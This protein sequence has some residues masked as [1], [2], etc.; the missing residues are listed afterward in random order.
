MATG[1]LVF[2]SCSTVST[3]ID[4]NRAAF[5]QLAP[6]DRE[7][8]RQ[9]KIRGGMSEEA[10]FIAWGRPEQ[11][12]TGEVRG[13]PTETWVYLA[14]TAAYA[15]Y[16]PGWYGGWGFSGRVAFIGGHG[17]HRVFAAFYDPLWDPFYYPFPATIQYPVKTVSFQRGRVIAFQYLTPGA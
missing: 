17:G 2:S 10:V 5:D 13:V 14:S 4:S 12:A 1:A 7:L 9:G 11:K 6:A 15:P 3:R 16:G 8:V